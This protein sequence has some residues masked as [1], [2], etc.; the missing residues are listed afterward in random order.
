MDDAGA[1]AVQSSMGIGVPA[2]GDAMAAPTDGAARPARWSEDLGFVLLGG[3]L[4][5][6]A[7]LDG[8]AHANV[9]KLETFFTPWHA[10]LYSG[11]VAVAGWL[12]AMVWHRRTRGRPPWTWPPPGYG[13]GL[14]A[15]GVFAVA[16]AGDLLWHLAF[17]IEQGIEAELSPTHLVL[18]AAAVVLLTSPLRSALRRHGSMPAG[19]EA[20]PA[21]LSVASATAVVALFLVTF[22]PFRATAGAGAAAA[23][24]YLIAPFTALDFARYMITTC[25]LVL[26]V[27]TVYRWGRRIPPGLIVATVAAVTLSAGVV[28]GFAQPLPLAAAIVGGLAADVLVTAVANQAPRLVPL[29]AGAAIPALVFGA[30]LAARALTTGLTW[31]IHV[32]LGLVVFTAAIGALFAGLLRPWPPAREHERAP[33]GLTVGA[34]SDERRS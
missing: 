12:V 27:L 21:M 15:V 26:P 22:S 1:G 24:S 10:V 17:G 18:M 31:R 4:V 23:S 34:V 9:P 19:R 16:G 20:L 6:G 30:Q 32:W 29:V 7:H 33:E 8:W 5:A 14:L 2:P 13:L 11:F 3:W 28:S 25:V